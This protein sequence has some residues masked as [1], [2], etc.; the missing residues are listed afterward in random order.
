MTNDESQS[1]HV[2]HSAVETQP[3]PPAWQPLTPRGVAAFAQASLG[4]LCC[5]QLIVALLAATT[6]VLFVRTDWF[7][8]VEEAINQLPPQGDI[9]NGLLFWRSNSPALL[10]EG[11]FLAFVVDLNHSGTVGRSAHVQ[12]ELG[13]ADFRICSL[14]GCLTVQ[15]PAGW[16]VAL[17]RTELEPWWGAWKPALMAFIF[18]LTVLVL[19]VNWWGLATLYCVPAWIIALY[20]DRDLRLAESWK[21]AA[22]AL[23][24]GALL[25]TTA[26]FFYGLNLI[27][28]VRLGLGAG[29]HI[30]VG[31]L[32]LLFSTLCLPRRGA[33]LTG[34]ANPFVVAP[35]GTGQPTT[36]D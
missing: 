4:T 16:V 33:R 15:Y 26:I 25:M 18:M 22:A 8:T 30:V 27:D 24:P 21:L 12:V 2:Q 34:K 36:G 19:I 11:I 1:G 28:P 14:P 35:P 5:W 9:H 10:A 17:N 31:W 3:S 32:Y 7:P 20:A 13:K 6:V 23:L 29:L